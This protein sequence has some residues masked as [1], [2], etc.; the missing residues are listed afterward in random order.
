MA[1]AQAIRRPIIIISKTTLFGAD[2]ESMLPID[3]GGIYLP[4]D[5]QI[6]ECS[7]APLVVSYESSHFS[8]LVTIGEAAES[9]HLITLTDHEGCLLPLQF[10]MSQTTK[11]SAS[12]WVPAF[13]SSANV[14]N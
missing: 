13:K 2:G 1:L 6:A 5:L 4:L 11:P 14:S 12:Q 8:A 3:F 9:S 10:F 7:K